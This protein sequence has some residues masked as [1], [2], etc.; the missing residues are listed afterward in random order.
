MLYDTADTGEFAAT[1]L[2]KLGWPVF[3]KGTRQSVRRST[4]IWP[5]TLDDRLI[6]IFIDIVF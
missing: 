6:W 1:A 3:E 4:S 2:L 5:L